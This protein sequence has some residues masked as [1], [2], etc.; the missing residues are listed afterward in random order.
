LYGYPKAPP[1]SAWLT[2]IIE[3]ARGDGARYSAARVPILAS[4]PRRSLTAV[5]K[6]TRS[7]WGTPP[8]AWLGSRLP[9]V[10]PCRFSKTFRQSASAR[11]H[12]VNRKWV[13]MG[14]PLLGPH[15]AR[16]R[17]AQDFL[18]T[19]ARRPGFFGRPSR[20]GPVPAAW[21]WPP[22]GCRFLWEPSPAILAGSSPSGRSTAVLGGGRWA[23]VGGA[24]GRSLCPAEAQPN[25][26][27][28]P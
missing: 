14:A 2:I 20:S 1:W 3:A 13:S 25:C 9:A 15:S 7:R 11:A 21:S 28:N 6:E 27:E 12:R 22:A 5:R 8:P 26:R 19:P 24:G 17:R 23:L 10:R 4:N 16:R 18:A